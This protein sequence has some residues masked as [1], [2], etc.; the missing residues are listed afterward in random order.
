MRFSC[1]PTGHVKLA[2]GETV[3]LAHVGAGEGEATVVD[4]IPLCNDGYRYILIMPDG[5]R[6]FATTDWPNRLTIGRPHRPLGKPSP[7]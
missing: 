2:V 6:R 7:D 5:I 3:N 1:T 4:R